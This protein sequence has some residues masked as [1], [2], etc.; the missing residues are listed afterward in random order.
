MA[1][2]VIRNNKAKW[3]PEELTERVLGSEI[4]RQGAT[5][6]TVT[7]TESTFEVDVVASVASP[8]QQSL[9]LV[10]PG[11]SLVE[12]VQSISQISY[13]DKKFSINF[14]KVGL[15]D[16]ALLGSA[17]I[18]SSIEGTRIGR[19]GVVVGEINELENTTFIDLVGRVSHL[20]VKGTC[21][22]SEGN[23]TKQ[24]REF[25]GG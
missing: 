4:T 23:G 12:A 7:S 1:I 20:A 24:N 25:H 19:P 6:V 14:V 15:P 11:A 13:M 2:S 21:V 22:A 8:P 10:T 9:E 17:R 5:A 3:S 16:R 18:E